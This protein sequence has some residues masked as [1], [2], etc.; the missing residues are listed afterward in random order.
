M[1]H[2]RS[3]SNCVKDHYVDCGEAKTAIHPSPIDSGG[4]NVSYVQRAICDEENHSGR[5]RDHAVSILPVLQ[6]ARSENVDVCHEMTYRVG[7]VS[8]R[9]ASQLLFFILALTVLM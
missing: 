5:G 7:V 4:H 6:E 3:L 1:G 9:I 8:A 2:T